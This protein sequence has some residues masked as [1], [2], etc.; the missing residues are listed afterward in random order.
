MTRGDALRAFCRPTTFAEV[1]ADC[2]PAY[3]NRIRWSGPEFQV[4]EHY[5]PAIRV[6]ARTVQPTA[7]R[8]LESGGKGHEEYRNTQTRTVLIEATDV[9]FGLLNPS[10]TW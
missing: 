1:V 10:R 8:S 6:S 9:I 4:L 3:R 5:A 7:K 2:R